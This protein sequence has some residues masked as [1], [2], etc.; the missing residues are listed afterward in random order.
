VSIGTDGVAGSSPTNGSG[1]SDPSV[2]ADGSRVAFISDAE[3]LVSGDTN[4]HADIFIRDREAKTTFRVPVTPDVGGYNDVTM[5]ADGRSIVFLTAQ[6]GLVPTDVVA[7]TIDIFRV[8]LGSGATIQVNLGTDA[9]P[10]EQI[11]IGTAISTDGR[12]VAF[13]AD[14]PN[15]VAG[16][17][18]DSNIYLRDTTAG[19]TSLLSADGNGTPANGT[20]YFG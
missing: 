3:N 19:T 6:P 18:A 1:A 17:T 9:T 4:G 11:S 2:T 13:R 7:G 5:S 20:S 15:T 8:D 14:D 16:T 12:Y 10:A